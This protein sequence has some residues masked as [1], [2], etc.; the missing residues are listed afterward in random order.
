METASQLAAS[1]I[2]PTLVARV[3]KGEVHAFNQLYD[4]SSTLLFSL[5]LR[6]LDNREEA[7]DV[8]QEIYLNVW[9]KVVRYDVGRGTPIAWLIT[10]TRNRAI[11]RL[12]ARGPRSLRQMA[13]S[14]DDGQTSHVADPSS[15]T[16]DSPADQD[17]R[18]LVVEAWV[19]LPQVQRQMIELAY[20]EG[21]PDAEIAAQLNQPVEAVKTCIALGMS[22]LLESLQSYWEAAEAV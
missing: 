3:A 22:Q 16:F 2:N 13:S 12:R 17:L 7:A 11:D 10:L 21:F 9:R 18:S 1:A 4:Q 14:I 8:L 19:S 15:D 20:Y 6:I 5:A